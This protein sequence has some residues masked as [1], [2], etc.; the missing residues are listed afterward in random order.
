MQEWPR[1]AGPRRVRKR[2]ERTAMNVSPRGGEKHKKAH[3][4]TEEGEDNNN[5]KEVFGV[6]RVIAEEQRDALGMLTQA[7]AQVAERMAAM[8]ACDEERLALEQET[9]EIQRAH[10]VMARRA[11]DR[12]EERLEM[13]RVQLSIAQQQTEDL[14]KMGTLMWSPFVYSSKG[15]ERAVKAEVEA[16]EGGEEVDDKDE[17]AQGEEE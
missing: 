14:W 6:P 17:D 8:E 10:L 7:L 1:V 11:T 15:K 3:T 4:T 9:V 5:T 13:D 16:E 2:A 12:E